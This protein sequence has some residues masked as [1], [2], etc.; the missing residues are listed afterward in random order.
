MS[1]VLWLKRVWRK[2]VSLWRRANNPNP[3]FDQL[4]RYDGL[5]LP[6]ACVAF[7]RPVFAPDG[8]CGFSLVGTPSHDLAPGEVVVGYDDRYYCVGRVAQAAE[9]VLFFEEQS[10]FA[11]MPEKG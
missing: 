5:G 3:T 10:F 4:T 11:P 1:I 8:T 9:G 2:F 7:D 6:I